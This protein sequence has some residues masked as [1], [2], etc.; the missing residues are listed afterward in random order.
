MVCLVG[1]CVVSASD[2]AT[3][4]LAYYRDTTMVNLPRLRAELRRGLTPSQAEIEE[5]IV[6]TVSMDGNLNAF[7]SMGKDGRRQIEIDAGLVQFADWFEINMAIATANARSRA[8]STRYLMFLIDGINN[9]RFVPQI[10]GWPAPASGN[11]IDFLRSHPDACPAPESL[12]AKPPGYEKNELV[13]ILIKCVVGH[14]L[15]HHLLGHLLKTSSTL[16]ESREQETQADIFALRLLAKSGDPAQVIPASGIA[17]LLAGVDNFTMDRESS[18]TH[19]AG[20]R[21]LSMFVSSWRELLN[22]PEIRAG[23]Q[24]NGQLQNTIAAVT[25]AEQTIDSLLKSQEH[26]LWF[27]SMVTYRGQDPPGQVFLHLSDIP[28]EHLGA[29]LDAG[30][31]I[32]GIAESADT[33]RVVLEKGVFGEQRLTISEQFPVEFI[34]RRWNEGFEVTTLA[35]DGVEW[36]V[37]MSKNSGLR[38]QSWKRSTFFPDSYIKNALSR[39]EFVTGLGRVGSTYGVVTSRTSAFANQT[40]SCSTT[41]LPKDFIRA[42]WHEGYFLTTALPLDGK[43]WCAVMSKSGRYLKQHYWITKDFLSPDI[44]DRYREGFRMLSVY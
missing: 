38:A 4:S 20:V 25:R 32:I 14:E 37:V 42:K 33:W 40:Y 11:P 23:L 35:S 43:G 41:N 3:K 29:F 39:G 12:P 8:C 18:S 9:Q 2:I 34:Q 19:P 15:G 13:G 36:V 5:S 22:D 28:S 1:A 27:V 30:Y 21:R 26:E 7:A 10:Q 44:L 16:A 17:F 24:R 31:S 6:Y